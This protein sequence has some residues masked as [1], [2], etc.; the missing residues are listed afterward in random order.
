MVRITPVGSPV[1]TVS[2]G[3][4]RLIHWVKNRQWVGVAEPQVVGLCHHCHDQAHEQGGSVG[5]HFADT[6]RG[7]GRILWDAIG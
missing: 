7:R 4:R 6:H 5:G 1:T 3:G 2:R